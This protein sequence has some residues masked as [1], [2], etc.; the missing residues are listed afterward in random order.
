LQARPKPRK[1]LECH[2]EQAEMEENEGI[3]VK[4]AQK[5]VNE[6]VHS[7]VLPTL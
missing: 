1:I 2:V 5:G 4:Q 3:Q 6:E 7:L